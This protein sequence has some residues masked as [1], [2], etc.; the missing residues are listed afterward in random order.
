MGGLLY[1]NYMIKHL[2]KALAIGAM[3]SFAANA[4]QVDRKQ[5]QK[6]E[7]FMRYVELGYVDS[8]D[9]EKLTE[10]AIKSVL[11]E[12]DPHSVY[13]SAKD[14]KRANEP[15]EGNFE[16]VGI[17]FNILHDTITVVS[18]ISGGPSQKLGI[19]AGDKIINIDGEV[20]AGVGFTNKDVADHLRGKKGT[21]V[22]VE[23]LRNGESELLRFDIIRDKIPIYSMDAAYLA[24]PNTGYVKLNRFAAQSMQE[25]GSALDSLQKMGMENLILDLRGNGGG[26]LRTAIQLADN[27]LKTDKL[28]VYTEG[29]TFPKEPYHSSTYGNF[30]NGKLVILIDEGSASASEIVSG[31]IQDWDRGLI[32]GRKSFGKG[33]VQKPFQLSDGSAIRL[34]I[35]RYYTPSGRCI[36]RDYSEGKDD[37]YNEVNK[38]FEHG[39]LMNSDSIDFPDS[40]KY[41][42]LQLQRTVY[43]GGGIMPDIFIPLDTTQTSKYFSQLVRKGIMYTY[44][45]D[46]LDDHREELLNTYPTFEDFESGFTISESM[47]E[48]LFKAAEEKEIA[49]N[50]EDIKTSLTLIK[51]NFKAL[52]ASNL[53]NSTA[54]Y[55]V[56]NTNDAA[57]LKAIEVMNDKTFKKLKLDYK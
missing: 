5:L 32:I 46:Y 4:Q 15:L 16:G 2:T 28:I 24:T 53:Y 26:Y 22:N 57:V 41:E 48:E 40:L 30:E 12:L 43:G 49:R 14:L 23:I 33:L 20:V 44:N 35:S 13:I 17:Q 7:T 37:Y 36:Q 8:V 11:K 51:N 56:L 6:M 42:T 55:R 31:A 25:V 18:P 50:E 39:E 3:V 27:F 10:T 38:R 34:T 19:R 45:L 52:M 47:L 9:A 1:F 54:F 29:R 21:K